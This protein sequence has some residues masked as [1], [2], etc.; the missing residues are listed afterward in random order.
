MCRLGLA[1]A[2]HSG[3]HPSHASYPQGIQCLLTVQDS[4]CAAGT[5]INAL[6]VGL[7]IVEGNTKAILTWDS[8]SA[9]LA[10]KYQVFV[11][12]EWISANRGQSSL[13]SPFKYSYLRRYG[14][15]QWPR[16]LLGIVIWLSSDCASATLE[17]SKKLYDPLITSIGDWGYTGTLSF[18][19]SGWDSFSWLD[20]VFINSANFDCSCTNFFS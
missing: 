20:W 18:T 19:S 7:S 4:G 14:S 2:L 16:I 8:C 13:H 12:R 17:A 6:V 3:W 9:P 1:I 15:C 5:P 11:L 10:S